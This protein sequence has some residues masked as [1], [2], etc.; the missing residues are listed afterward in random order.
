MLT[1]WFRMKYPGTV[2]GAIAGSAPIL[3]FLYPVLNLLKQPKNLFYLMQDTYLEPP[4][5]VNSY[6]STS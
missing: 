1:S 5:D 2:D 6:P 3:A 4:Y